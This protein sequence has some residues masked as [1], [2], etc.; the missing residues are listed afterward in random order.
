[1]KHDGKQPLTSRQEGARTGK[2]RVVSERD[3]TEKVPVSQNNDGMRRDFFSLPKDDGTGRQ[4]T[5]SMCLEKRRDGKIHP[6]S[7]VFP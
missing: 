5:E 4:G 7:W 3:G 2:T 1:M 6:V